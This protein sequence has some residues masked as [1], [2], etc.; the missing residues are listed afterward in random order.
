[1]V[2]A[3]WLIRTILERS[4]RQARYHNGFVTVALKLKLGMNLC[5]RL[6]TIS[7]DAGDYIDDSSPSTSSAT[8]SVASLSTG[9]E[10]VR[11]GTTSS[12][13]ALVMRCGATCSDGAVVVRC[14]GTCSDEAVV[15]RCG[16][17]C[18]DG[19]LA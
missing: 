17:T 5:I 8:S 19:A 18:S 11:R 3:T 13:G 12:D 2:G 1:M 15:V 6:W 16:A 10:V 14:G 7:G 9:A 4:A